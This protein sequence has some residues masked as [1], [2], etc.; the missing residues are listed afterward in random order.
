MFYS[1]TTPKFAQKRHYPRGESDETYY[2]QDP[3]LNPILK[4]TKMFNSYSNTN[5]FS[6]MEIQNSAPI[7][8][9]YTAPHSF[10]FG[11]NKPHFGNQIYNNGMRESF[12]PSK[13][14]G[15]FIE[16]ERRDREEEK[17]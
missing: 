17:R 13:M 2:C 16:E 1:R 5:K 9:K 14:Q 8:Y 6:D 11:M 10:G 12:Q 4:K 3:D 7:T 15:G